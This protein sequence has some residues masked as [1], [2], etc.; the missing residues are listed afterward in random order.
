MAASRPF[1]RC[2]RISIGATGR[3]YSD[4]SRS[5]FLRA[6]PE[7][8]HALVPK[9]MMDFHVSGGLCS[10]PLLVERGKGLASLIANLG[11]LPPATPL[12]QRQA[13]ED[14]VVTSEYCAKTGGVQWERRFPGAA[15]PL[16]SRWYFDEK[17][18]L[19]VDSFTWLGI[20]D[21]A[22]FGFELV[23]VPLEGG[24]SAL[25]GFRHVT[26]RAW[27]FGVPVPLGLALTADG[28]SMPHSDGGGWDVEVDV[29]HA[30]LGTV[31]S[32]RGNVR[33]E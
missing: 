22:A 8:S 17:S 23:P 25:V 1:N 3:F 6:L 12:D 14:V 31:V 9:G 2:L 27:V 4:S 7:S 33:L 18:G 24:G 29:S 5:P 15:G 16:S 11:Q 28:V 10:G 20:K 13:P 30:L 26:K 19:A 21:F 32:Y